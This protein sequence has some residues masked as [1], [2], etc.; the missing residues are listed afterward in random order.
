[1]HTFRRLF[2]AHDFSPASDEALRQAHE[3]AQGTGGHLAVCHIIPN[4]LRSDLLFPHISR[5][6]AL[7]IPLEMTQVADT[8]SARVIEITG[9]TEGKFEVIV[10]D[11]TPQALLLSHAEEWKADLLFMGSHGQTS[12]VD[13]MLGSITNSVIR[14]AHCPVFIVRHGRQSK[15]IIAGTDFSEPSLPAIKAAADEAERTDS[16]LTVVHSL[17]LIWTPVSYPA[18][19]FGGAPIEMSPDQI[20]ELEE[21][22]KKKLDDLLKHSH[23]TAETRVVTGS[24]GTALIEIASETKAQLIVV[25]TVG[26]TGLRRA[27][28]GSVAEA[29]AKG[30]PCSVLVVRAEKKQQ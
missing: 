2:V 4:D 17:D 24:A 5:V 12:A 19:A 27:L 11:G 20:Q 8:L 9:R 28:L 13:V 14:H 18:M 23:V 21:I 7:K 15:R 16:K 29:V 1:M 3:R 22:A 10:D 30:A 25:G 6:A 26:R